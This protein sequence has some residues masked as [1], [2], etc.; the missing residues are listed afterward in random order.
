VAMEEASRFSLTTDRVAPG[1]VGLLPLLLG[2][3]E[4]GSVR[5]LTG[6]R[7]VSGKCE[8][9]DEVGTGGAGEGEGEYREAVWEG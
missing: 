5:S 8:G 4:R 3:A 7:R 1:G 9:R 2:G 6:A